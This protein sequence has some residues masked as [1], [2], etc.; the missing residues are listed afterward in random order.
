MQILLVNPSQSWVY[1]KLSRPQYPPLGLAYIA[2]VLEREG[3]SIKIIDIDAEHFS[4]EKFLD[5]VKNGDFGIVGF[6]ATT[7]TFIKVQKLLQICKENSDAV[8]ILGGIHA[9][10]SPDLF[11]KLPYLDFV[12]KGEGED[13]IIDLIKTIGGNRNYENVKG[14]SF[15]KD[16]QLIN[17]ESRELISNLDTLPFPARHLFKQY[18]YS[19]PDSLK[20]PVIPIM[21]SRGC[22]YGCTYCCT[23]LIFTR[24]IRF[25]SAKNVVD[26]IEYLKDNYG[27]REIHFWDDN[28]TFD[29]ERVFKI[30][31]ELKKRNIKLKY[32]FP[33]GLRVDRVD[34]EILKCLKDMG[35]YS[36]AFGVESGNQ[37]ILN[38][39]EKGTTL[40]QIEKAYEM[41][42]RVGLETWG[43]FILGLV[44]EN[45][46][47][48][49]DTIDFAKKINPDV[50][51][52][53]VLKPFPGTKAFHQLKEQN[54]ILSEDYTRY[55]IHTKPVHRLPDV[56]SDELEEYVKIAYR[57]FYLRFFKIFNHLIRTFRSWDR[58]KLNV[59][60]MLGVLRMMK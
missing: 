5:T 40:K 6:T 50:A 52:F 12:V 24:Q 8:T 48:I 11:A 31:D 57:E 60:T 58:F 53:H 35:V 1:G 36:M 41:A 17:T 10:I 32:A 14:I 46:K 19:Y 4:D 42:K 16:G 59:K 23:K 47:T 45:K 49:R 29:R 34:E 39:A 15:K 55:G 56:T 22:P 38:M 2:A 33:N 18:V 3:H 51:K 9:T 7:P 37:D 20:N 28:F 43:F 13:T 44:G 54:L 30:H 26:E 21:T 27:A 25:R